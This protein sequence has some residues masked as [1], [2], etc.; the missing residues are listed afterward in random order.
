MIEPCM[1]LQHFERSHNL[2]QQHSFLQLKYKGT[3]QETL[4]W[5]KENFKMKKMSAVEKY[6]DNGLAIIYYFFNC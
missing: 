3:I 6:H 2:N 5:E 1:H 4:I